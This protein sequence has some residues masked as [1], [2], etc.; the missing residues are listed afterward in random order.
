M[1]HLHDTTENDA[2]RQN[3]SYIELHVFH[4][5][6]NVPLLLSNGINVFCFFFLTS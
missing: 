4:K 6:N 5:Y 1:I 3:D 2:R